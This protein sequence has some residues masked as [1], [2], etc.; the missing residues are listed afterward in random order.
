MVVLLKT[1]ARDWSTGVVMNNNLFYAPNATKSAANY[2][3]SGAN[4]TF[5][6][7][8]NASNADG[9]TS[10]YYTASNNSSNSQIKSTVPGFTIP[11][12]TTLSTWKPTSGYSIGGGV[13]KPVY[14]DFFK[15]PRT[16]TFSMGGALQ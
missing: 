8:I 15:V 11:P 6:I 12:T 7:M 3:S 13:W 4:G 10:G 9:E 14:D 5:H 2:Q 16:G 1:S